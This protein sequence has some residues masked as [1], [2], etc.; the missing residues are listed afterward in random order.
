MNR[1]GSPTS[2]SRSVSVIAVGAVL[3]GG[4]AAA[5]LVGDAARGRAESPPRPSPVARSA[6][7]SAWVTRT[8][9]S[10]LTSYIRAQSSTSASATGSRPNAPPALLTSTSQRGPTAAASASTDA[11]SVTSQATAGAADLLGQRRR[12]GPR[13]GRRATT[14]KPS[15]AS[16]R[17]V[18][19]PMPLLAPVTTAV[20]RSWP[21]SPCTGRTGRSA[22]GSAAQWTTG[23]AA[24]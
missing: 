20:A 12:A 7:S 3:G 1:T 24:L 17:A 2:S 14:S 21:H 6:G 9:P 22:I 23:V 13:G 18:A 5:A 19:A 11:A 4:V 8:R 16:A 10:T 15:A